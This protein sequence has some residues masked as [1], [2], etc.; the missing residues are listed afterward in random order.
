MRSKLQ[1]KGSGKTLIESR[2]FK[3]GEGGA[4]NALL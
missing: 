2:K 4:I 3:G 1:S